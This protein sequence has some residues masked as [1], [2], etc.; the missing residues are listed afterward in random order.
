MCLSVQ[1]DWF[2][3]NNEVL[4]SKKQTI[5]K[6]N[7]ILGA[8]KLSVS[9]VVFKEKHNKIDIFFVSVMLQFDTLRS[10]ETLDD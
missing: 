2:F 1:I 7:K 10:Y 3:L 6:L 4:L 8:V 5:L 9:R